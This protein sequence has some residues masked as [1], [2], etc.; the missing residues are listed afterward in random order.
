MIGSVPLS[1]LVICEG[2]ASS[3][4]RSAT[5]E[6]RSRTSLAAASRSRSSENSTLICERSSRLEEFRRSTP[7]MPEISFS[8]TCVMRDSTTSEDG[9]AIARLDVDYRAIDVGKFAQRKP[10]DRA[11]AEDEQQQRHHR[12][13]YRTAHRQVRDHHCAMLAGERAGLVRL[14]G[15]AA[16]LRHVRSALATRVPARRRELSACLRRPPVRRHSG[17]RRSRRCQAGVP[18]MRTSRRCALPSAT[19]NT[20]CRSASGVSASSGMTS[21]SRSSFASCTLRNM[22]GLSAPSS[23]ANNARTV[24]ERVFMSTRESMLATVPAKV[25]PGNAGARARIDRPSRSACEK[26]LRH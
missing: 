7:S 9:A 25:R 3:G 20:N 14:V 10:H 26:I 22:P 6:R 13:E 12:R 19:T 4:R 17:R 8:M 1:T 2:S 23:L 21:A 18:P 5:R 15:I 24:T 11:H 16:R